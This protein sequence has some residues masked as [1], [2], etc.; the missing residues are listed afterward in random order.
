L[1]VRK[2]GGRSLS[3]L[4]KARNWPQFHSPQNISTSLAAEA[5]KLLETFQWLTEEQSEEIVYNEKEM[6]LV[7]I[8][9]RNS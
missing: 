4:P 2:N 8:K 6:V 1:S 3:C 9:G 7:K 5:Q